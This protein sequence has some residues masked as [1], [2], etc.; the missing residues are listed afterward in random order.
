MRLPVLIIGLGLSSLLAFSGI[1]EI[2]KIVHEA[3]QEEQQTAHAATMASKDKMLAHLISKDA[4][5]I[6]F[7][8]RP[9]HYTNE[10]QNAIDRF[11][12]SLIEIE[13]FAK[14][15]RSKRVVEELA[16]LK[17]AWGEYKNRALSFLKTKSDKD[18]DYLTHNAEVVMRLA[19]RLNQSIKSRV[20]LL[21]QP[22]EALKF[23]LEFA[24]R[25]RMLD[26]RMVDNMLL[27]LNPKTS[28]DKK[29]AQIKLRGSIILFKDDLE[30][31]LKGDPKR[32]ILK[33]VNPQMRATL[34][35]MKKA[36]NELLKIYKDKKISRKD[37]EKLYELDRA[38]LTQVDKFY[39][40]VSDAMEL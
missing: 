14:K 33:V 19:H 7:N 40:Q 29:R 8:V 37:I 5:F 23:T 21:A 36:F 20:Y 9:D 16:T 2:Q 28:Y 32:E 31:L 24:S 4:S 22:N 35:D 26:Q 25:M 1:A 6:K 10:M 13:K 11:D 3:L 15:D 34:L 27:L 30:G 17:K 12:E 18:Y 39:R 38:L